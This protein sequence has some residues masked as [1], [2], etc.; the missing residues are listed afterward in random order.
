M[1]VHRCGP[2]GRSAR[3]FQNTPSGICGSAARRARSAICL[4]RSN[5]AGERVSRWLAPFDAKES[6]VPKCRMCSQEV[7]SRGR[8]CQE[9]EW[10]FESARA[11]AE[12]QDARDAAVATVAG[13]AVRAPADA[14][15]EADDAAASAL[16]NSGGAATPD[17]VHGAADTSYNL[18]RTRRGAAL[19][20]A[21]AGSAVLVGFASL[22][23]AAL[24]AQAHRSV[25]DRQPGM[26][27]PCRDAA[28][29]HSC[30]P[31]PPR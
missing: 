11:W 16:P 5:R 31:L 20:L 23:P 21:I 29:V 1:G 10:E 30:L 12:A 15:D 13:Q 24:P 27:P 22:G 6:A 26:L 14:F 18:W 17:V 25:M 2:A 8:I 3:A 19:L 28:P 4:G 9:C 7:N